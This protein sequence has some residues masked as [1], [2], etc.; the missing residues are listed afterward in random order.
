MGLPGAGPRL[1]GAGLQRARTAPL[2]ALAPASRQTRRNSALA[3][4]KV[5][6]RHPPAIKLALAELDAIAG[7]YREPDGH[8]LVI[9][10]QGEDLYEKDQYGVIL[11]L[12]AETAS[13][14][15]YPNGASLIRLVVEH[16]RRAGLLPLFTTTIAMRSGGKNNPMPA[17]KPPLWPDPVI[18][19][20]NP[21]PE[22]AY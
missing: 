19:R 20:G 1:L 17:G 2:A 14:L 13:E 18:D 9:Y 8:T 22:A 21:Y 3:E 12:S 4:R 6:P 7:D 16:D 5:I 10:R 15:F 11:A